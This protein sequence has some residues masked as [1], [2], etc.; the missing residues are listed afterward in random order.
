MFRVGNKYYPGR[1]NSMYI[2]PT[3]G[4]RRGR[5]HEV[6]SNRRA[7]IHRAGIKSLV[8]IF[9]IMGSHRNTFNSN[10]INFQI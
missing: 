10:M 1:E 8:F 2:N 9:S 6:R 3:W 5:T 7:R 4:K